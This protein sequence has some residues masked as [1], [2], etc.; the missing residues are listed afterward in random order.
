MGS[1][2]QH[3]LAS[4]VLTL[5]YFRTLASSLSALSKF[6]KHLSLSYVQPN[7][8]CAMQVIFE[9][10]QP[11]DAQLRKL[12]EHRVRFV[13]RCLVWLVPRVR[14]YMSDVNGQRG[15]V[16]KRCQV[17]LVT[18][19]VGSVVISSTARNWHIALQDALTRATQVLKRNVQRIRS[20]Q[21]TN[22]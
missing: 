21:R 10:P 12:L 9:T 4:V 7:G 1:S 3:G 5:S 11:E 2:L 17:E 8:V 19:S 14:V 6:K 22:E 16:D 20:K 13:M 18:E 15:G